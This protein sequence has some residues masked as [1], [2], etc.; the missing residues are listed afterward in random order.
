MYVSVIAIVK[1]IV[2]SQNIFLSPLPASVLRHYSESSISITNR[3]ARALANLGKSTD[4]EENLEEDVV[5]ILVHALDI[6]E[7]SGCSH[8]LLRVLK[9]FASSKN[10]TILWNVIKCGGLRVVCEKS[11]SKDSKLV[12]LAVET[13]VALTAP[14]DKRKSRCALTLPVA[15][16]N[17][18]L[19][20]D[21][22][23]NIFD[24][25]SHHRPEV[26]NHS[27]ECIGNLMS[28]DIGRAALGN[29]GFVKFYLATARNE[30]V[31]KS[32]R[33]RCAQYLCLC[34][35]ESVNRAKM[36]ELHGLQFL[37]DLLNGD[38]DSLPDVPSAL[39]IAAIAEFRFDAIAMEQFANH[40]LVKVLILH[41]QK[42]VKAQSQPPEEDEES[43]IFFYVVFIMLFDG[44]GILLQCLCF[45]LEYY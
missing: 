14:F 7:D 15:A 3:C 43:K 38:A 18:V 11:K 17:P 45:K 8:S 34:C 27:W 19:E 16:A 13:A 26:Q 24:L 44:H 40:N 6:T 2:I 10:K 39:V 20:N 21:S 35:Q 29:A 32:V 23:S 37:I 42:K 28:S 9:I 41:L 12:L 30:D 36:S 1:Y 5:P 25:L 22:L 31:K 4:I 33:E